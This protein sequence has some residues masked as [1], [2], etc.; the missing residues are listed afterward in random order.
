MQSDTIA[1]Y[2]LCTFRTFA[3]TGIPS[4]ITHTVIIVIVGPYTFE[5][6]IHEVAVELLN[7]IEGLVGVQL[8]NLFLLQ[9]CLTDGSANTTSASGNVMVL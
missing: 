6:R 4:Y 8:G 2:V 9:I 7:I 3:T 5:S 1:Y